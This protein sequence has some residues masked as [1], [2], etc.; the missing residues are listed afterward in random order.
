[1]KDSGGW[2]DI[3]RARYW[4]I[5]VGRIGFEQLLRADFS[6]WET[7]SYRNVNLTHLFPCTS[8]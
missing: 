3:G 1:V 7:N 5:Q 8:G 2:F 6:G 4:K